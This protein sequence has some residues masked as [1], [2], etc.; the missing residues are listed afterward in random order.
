[1]M[2]NTPIR[3]AHDSVGSAK[4]H[5]QI[6]AC[7]VMMLKR[8]DRDDTRVSK[9]K[10]T[11]AI[12]PMPPTHRLLAS[13]P[14]KNVATPFPPRNLS[15]TG[16]IW[17]TS[18]ARNAPEAKSYWM[19]AQTAIQPLLRSHRSVSAPTVFPAVRRAFVAPI[20]PDP[21]VRISCPVR[22]RVKIRPKG[23]LPKR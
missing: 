6:I 12:M 22:M 13:K 15:H 4:R 18:T 2:R 11:H 9:K 3:I 5:N 20:F 7:V 8:L 1:M 23:I 10:P 16:N 14:P 17:P 19:P 21:F